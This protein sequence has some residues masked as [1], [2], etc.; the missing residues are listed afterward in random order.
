V[1]ESN[2]FVEMSSGILE[3][4]HGHLIVCALDDGIDKIL[5]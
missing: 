5:T 1:T 4:R 3:K 2:F